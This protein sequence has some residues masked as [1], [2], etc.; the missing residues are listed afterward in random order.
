MLGELQLWYE[1]GLAALENGEESLVSTPR[2][3]AAV[4][5][6]AAL[7]A[8]PGFGA[9]MQRIAQQRGERVL[10]AGAQ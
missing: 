7:R 9:L 10:M 8:S 3:D 4:A 1:S 5:R 6:Y 2:H